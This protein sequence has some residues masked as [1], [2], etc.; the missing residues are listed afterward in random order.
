M[1]SCLRNL[2][3]RPRNAPGSRKNGHRRAASMLGPILLRF[4]KIDTVA[5]TH[6]RFCTTPYALAGA[7]RSSGAQAAPLQA[8][9]VVG[10]IIELDVIH[11]KTN[12]RRNCSQSGAMGP[13]GIN[14]IFCGMMGLHNGPLPAPRP[15]GSGRRLRIRVAREP[16]APLNLNPQD[17][18]QMGGLSY[19]YRTT[20]T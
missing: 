4:W 15:S 9:A 17:Q 11:V 1:R 16:I 7:C 19:S 6:G 20:I 14:R 3:P 13:R 10:K 5:A 8:S 12:R 2:G 18:N